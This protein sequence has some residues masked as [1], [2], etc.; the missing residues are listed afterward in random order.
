M[1]SGLANTELSR[2]KLRK[3][4][5]EKLNHTFPFPTQQQ[6]RGAGPPDPNYR[7]HQTTGLP[8]RPL[9][10]GHSV[11]YHPRENR[12]LGGGVTL[13]PGGWSGVSICEGVGR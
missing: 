4:G 12:G 7:S 5:D 9:P 8:P 13:E 11:T 1:M 10:P 2:Q 3:K 6:Q